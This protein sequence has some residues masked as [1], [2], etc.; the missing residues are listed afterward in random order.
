MTVLFLRSF[1]PRT[2]GWEGVLSSR[3]EGEVCMEDWMS[4]DRMLPE[5]FQ[6]RGAYPCP[7]GSWCLGYLEAMSDEAL[8]RLSLPRLRDQAV[9][10]DLVFAEWKG[11]Y[12]ALWRVIEQQGMTPYL[13]AELSKAARALRR[14]QTQQRR[15]RALLQAASQPRQVER[16]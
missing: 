11:R 15:L 8:R 2:W 10:V 1:L 7:F 9:S 12:T 14:I 5:V 16:N 4:Y 3:G 6:Q 13:D